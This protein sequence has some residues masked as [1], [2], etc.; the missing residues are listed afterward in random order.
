MGETKVLNQPDGY[1]K[2]YTVGQREEMSFKPGQQDKLK[3]LRNPCWFSWPREVLPS[4]GGLK[5]KKRKSF[6]KTNKRQCVCVCV[7]TSDSSQK[8][9]SSHSA[10][11]QTTWHRW[12]RE[13]ERERDRERGGGGRWRWGGDWESWKS[14]SY[15]GAFIRFVLQLLVSDLSVQ[16]GLMEAYS[17]CMRACVGSQLL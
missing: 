1:S 15:N 4:M 13:K 11:L 16:T 2:L 10:D 3:Q 7:F 5:K 9:N 6:S 17:V 14:N 8:T 12:E